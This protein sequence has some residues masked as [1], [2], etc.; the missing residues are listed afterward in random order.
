MPDT[1]TING[2]MCH[3]H[4]DYHVPTSTIYCSVCN[5]KVWA[6]NGQKIF[7]IHRDALGD[8]GDILHNIED[9]QYLANCYD[10]KCIKEASV[11]LICPIL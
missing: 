2:V 5:L 1:I 10:K 11:Q 6:F 3:D 8:Y 9:G 4:G 7:F